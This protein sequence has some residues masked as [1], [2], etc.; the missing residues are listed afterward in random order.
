MKSFF[1]IFL[2]LCTALTSR[3]SLSAK[4][5]GGI[6]VAAFCQKHLPGSK[7]VIVDDAGNLVLARS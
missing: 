1:V 6:Q 4:D 2:I 5:L 7:A 3:I